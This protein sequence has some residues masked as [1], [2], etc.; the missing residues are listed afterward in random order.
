MDS[1]SE[2]TALR[3][4]YLLASCDMELAPQRWVW[5]PF[6]LAANAALN[7]SLFRP[8]RRFSLFAEKRAAPWNTLPPPPLQE[9]ALPGGR[10]PLKY[11]PWAPSYFPDDT[12][13]IA[14]LQGKHVWIMESA[15]ADLTYL[16]DLLRALGDSIQTPE[17]GCQAIRDGAQLFSLARYAGFPNALLRLY[18]GFATDPTSRNSAYSSWG[19]DSWCTSA[20]VVD[21]IM[22]WGPVHSVKPECVGLFRRVTG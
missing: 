16:A 10:V 19:Q 20:S 9:R 1:V 15:K 6:D 18:P 13:D 12:L 11:G 5:G 4:F 2:R 3:W 8:P 14:V 7:S 22:T 21:S 17:D